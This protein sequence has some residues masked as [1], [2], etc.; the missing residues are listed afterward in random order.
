MKQNPSKIFKP[1][2]MTLEEIDEELR[3]AGLNRAAIARNLNVSQT[4][5][6]QVARGIT[7]SHRIQTAFAEAIHKTAAQVFP[8][9]YASGMPKPGRK[10]AVW[11]RK[12]A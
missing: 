5:V 7:N 9:R 8:S 6:S 10:I 3:K 12:A 2:D 4:T 11:N 1:V